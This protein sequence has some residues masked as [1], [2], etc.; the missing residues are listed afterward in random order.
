MRATTGRQPPR[1]VDAR[2]GAEGTRIDLDY[3]CRMDIPS[4]LRV[5]E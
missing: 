3:V 1:A 2:A 5:A 4:T